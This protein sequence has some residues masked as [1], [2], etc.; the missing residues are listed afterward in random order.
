MLP[1]IGSDGLEFKGM[2]VHMHG[3]IALLLTLFGARL[4]G[5]WET[6]CGLCEMF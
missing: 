4:T 2:Q 3:Q 1:G 6:L 5:Q